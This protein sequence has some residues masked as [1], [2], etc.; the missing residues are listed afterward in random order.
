MKLLKH[1]EDEPIPKDK[2]IKKRFA[3]RAVL[4]DENGLTP[5]VFASKMN[6]HKI[7]GGGV[8]KGESKIKALIREIYEE[9][10]CTAEIE[11]EIGK[12]TEYRSK[13][14]WFQYQTSYCFHGKIVKKGKPHFDQGEVKEGFKMGWLTL[15]EAIETLRNDKPRDYEGSFIQQR[16]LAFLEEAKKLV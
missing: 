6:Y 15:D 16:D 7:P 9:A 12:I 14:K 8:E 1:I 3:V 4:L 5:V 10:G 2:K 11:G 13:F